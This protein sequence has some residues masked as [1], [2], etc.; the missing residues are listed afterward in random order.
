MFN[1]L[2]AAVKRPAT[3]TTADS[4]SGEAADSCEYAGVL[5]PSRVKRKKVTTDTPKATVAVLKTTS[6]RD[7]LGKTSLS[8][9]ID[10]AI[11]L[12]LVFEVNLNCVNVTWLSCV[13]STGP[14]AAAPK[15]T[16]GILS[17]DE[18]ISASLKT[19][20]IATATSTTATKS[21]FH[22]S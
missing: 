9:I 7:R 11:K 3:S 12:S 5:Q 22:F 15:A 2:G 18:P 16:E 13:R 17:A 1:R 4:D 8:E 10:G 21:K 14:Q 19:K 20:E 6:V